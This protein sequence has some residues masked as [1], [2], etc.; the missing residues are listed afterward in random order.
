MH[1]KWKDSRQLPETFSTEKIGKFFSN[2]RFS[3]NLDIH[4]IV[5]MV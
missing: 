5:P 4:L 3:C 2:L 1:N